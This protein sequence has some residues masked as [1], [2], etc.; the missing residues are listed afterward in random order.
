[1]LES[2]AGKHSSVPLQIL[3]WFKK[4]RP[5]FSK[6]KFVFSQPLTFLAFCLRTS[7]CALLLLNTPMLR[8]DHST[9]G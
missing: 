6:L 7:M 4:Q 1:M 5:K 2:I 8:D 9:T 3:I